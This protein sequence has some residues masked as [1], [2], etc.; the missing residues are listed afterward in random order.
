MKR[1]IFESVRQ[2]PHETSA[3]PC[4]LPIVYRDGAQLGVFYA[5]SLE[6]A[7]AV[8]EGTILEPW[9]MFGRAVTTL[10]AW[11][12]RDST[13][14]T[15]EEVGLGIIARKRGTRPSLLQLGRDMRDQ[16]DQGIWVCT[17]PVTTQAAYAAGVELWGYPKY[18][19]PIT[20]DFGDREA[21]V[22]LGDELEI[23]V[24]TG[25]TLPMPSLPVV[26]LTARGGRLIRTIIETEMHLSWTAGRTATVKVLG[27]GPTSEAFTALGLGNARPLCAF[28]TDGFRAVLPEG[29]DI[30]PARG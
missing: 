22:R 24:E 26:T 15:Y 17:L 11:T 8:L 16:E 21:R 18:V 28:R 19:T 12:Y 30:G 6:R 1:D 14:G 25:R 4:D 5:S 13:V 2:E 9:P 23:T 7:R 29:R 3:G 27:R 10:Q 20:S